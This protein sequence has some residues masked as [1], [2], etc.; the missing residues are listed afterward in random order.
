MELAKPEEAD[1]IS[2]L[3]HD[4]EC[5]TQLVKCAKVSCE[6]RSTPDIY[7]RHMPLLRVVGRW[8]LRAGYPG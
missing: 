1:C 5:L 8:S 7:C 4:V 3:L 6:I 2:G